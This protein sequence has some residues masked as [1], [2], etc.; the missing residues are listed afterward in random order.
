M[1]HLLLEGDL[2]I[3]RV[4]LEIFLVGPPHIQSVRPTG[5]DALLQGG[6]FV[7]ECDDIESWEVVL[8]AGL[9]SG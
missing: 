9:Q 5:I 6:V 8:H 1:G 2:S 4:R 7:V 3:M